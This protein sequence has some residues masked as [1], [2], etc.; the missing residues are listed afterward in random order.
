MGSPDRD[1][2]PTFGG[3]QRFAGR[4]LPMARCPRVAPQGSQPIARGSTVIPRHPQQLPRAGAFHFSTARTAVDRLPQ[5]VHP[6]AMTT[7]AHT[8]ERSSDS[9]ASMTASRCSEATGVTACGV[10]Q[11]RHATTSRSTSRDAQGRGSQGRRRDRQP[12]TRGGR[13]LTAPWRCCPPATM[14]CAPAPAGAWPP[15]LAPTR[16]P[17]APQESCA[18]APGS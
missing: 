11:C 9:P 10:G 16:R 18:T 17:V 4:T 12:A 7:S 1:T 6:A 15:H 5:Q 13:P 3:P 8:A 2:E 14:G